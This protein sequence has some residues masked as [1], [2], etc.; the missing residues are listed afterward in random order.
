MAFCIFTVPDSIQL[1]C[2]GHKC[3]FGLTM[4]QFECLFLSLFYAILSVGLIKILHCRVLIAFIDYPDIFID[5]SP[6]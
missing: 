3:F 5:L 6:C 2:L 4:N 1:F